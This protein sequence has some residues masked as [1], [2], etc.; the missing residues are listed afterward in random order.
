MRTTLGAI[1]AKNQLDRDPPSRA[2]WAD[3]TS[4][5]VGQMHFFITEDF[6]LIFNFT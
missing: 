4:K 1:V 2:Q 3:S 6:K 5:R